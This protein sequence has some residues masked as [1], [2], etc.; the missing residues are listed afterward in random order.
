M[1]LAFVLWDGLF[2][3]AERFTAALAGEIRSQ[4]VATSV[5]FVGKGQPLTAQLKRASVPFS[6]LDYPRGAHVLFHARSLARMVEARGADA[7]VIGGFG[8]LGAALRAGGF[9]GAILG[10]EHG[11][12]HQIPSMPLYKRLWRRAD[13]ASGVPTHDAEIAVSKYM[14]RLARNTLHARRLVRIAHGVQIGDTCSITPVDRSLTI[15]YAGRLVEGK[16]VDVLLHAIAQ[17]SRK[18]AEHAPSLRVAGDGPRRAS[19]QA[20]ARD[21]EID[22]HVQFLGWTDDVLNFWRGCNLAVAPAS[23]LAESFS[24][25]SLEAMAAGRPVI[26]TERG[27]LP[28]LVLDKETGAVVPPGDADALAAAIQIY[29]SSPHLAIT[30]GRAA[31]RLA[32]DQFNLADC[33]RAYVQ[34]AQETLD[35]RRHYAH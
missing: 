8:Y 32:R 34:L 19:L 9:R 15:G 20:L 18:N 26:V 4:N 30:H 33:A 7:A 29:V 12:L 31:Q 16:G 11:I 22:Q 23:E 6:A 35:A 28:E 27:A 3:G 1:N 21:L 14:E 24:M 25:T 13:R 5:V 10:V 2:G 17:L